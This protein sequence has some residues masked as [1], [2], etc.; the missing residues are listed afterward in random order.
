ML[1]PDGF[2]KWIICSFHLFGV[3]SVR[4]SIDFCIDLLQNIGFVLN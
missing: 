4:L 2:V 1:L 3:K